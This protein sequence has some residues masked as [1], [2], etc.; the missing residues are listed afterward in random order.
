MS[1][2]F[3]DTPWYVM[4]CYDI[5]THEMIHYVIRTRSYICSYDYMYMVC[6]YNCPRF[7]YTN[8][9]TACVHKRT[10]VLNYFFFERCMYL[11]I[12]CYTHMYTSPINTLRYICLYPYYICWHILSIIRYKILLYFLSHFCLHSHCLMYMRCPMKTM[13]NKRIHIYIYNCLCICIHICPLLCL[14]ICSC[15]HIWCVRH[16]WSDKVISRALYIYITHLI[17]TSIF[18]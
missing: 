9:Y 8:M 1:L 15:V 10:N 13:C 3:R 7:L 4:I 5:S 14:C 18:R 11:C 16:I 12:T 6:T 17:Y 2:I